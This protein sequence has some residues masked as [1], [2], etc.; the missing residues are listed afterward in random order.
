[1]LLIATS[2]LGIWI[3]LSE[4]YEIFPTDSKFYS[5]DNYYNEISLNIIGIIPTIPISLVL[6]ALRK[7]SLSL[8]LLFV[9]VSL[10]EIIVIIPLR[11]FS[12]F[13]DYSPDYNNKGSFIYNSVN[14]IVICSN[15]NIFFFNRIILY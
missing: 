15:L 8:Y 3:W 11:L 1:M 2:F 4:I 13:C 10:I 14:G 12:S 6:V 9:I 5:N 7:R